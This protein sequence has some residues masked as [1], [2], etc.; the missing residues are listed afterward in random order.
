ME[1]SKILKAKENQLICILSTYMVLIRIEIYQK[2]SCAVRNVFEKTLILLY[3][4]ETCKSYNGLKFDSATDIGER[5]E[6]WKAR[7]N[8]W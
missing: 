3:V 1:A 2:A 5:N 4:E 6:L 8:A 7:H